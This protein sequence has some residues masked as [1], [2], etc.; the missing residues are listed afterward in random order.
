MEKDVHQKKESEKRE[1]RQQILRRKQKEL[2][3]ERKRKKGK[4][5]NKYGEGRRK[6]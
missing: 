1:S 4:A 3:K 5:D 6:T 2:T